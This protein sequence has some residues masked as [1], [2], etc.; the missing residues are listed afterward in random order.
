MD[1]TKANSRHPQRILMQLL[2]PALIL[3]FSGPLNLLAADDVERESALRLVERFSLHRIV[4]S[5][6]CF[7][8]HSATRTEGDLDLGRFDSLDS[9]QSDLK[10]WEAMIQQLETREMPPKDQPQ[11]TDQERT[12]LLRWIRDILRVEA[13]RHAGDPGHVPLHR[14]SNAEYDNTIRDLTGVDLKPTRDFPSDGAA[15]EGFTNAA[16]SLSM[17]PAMMTKYIGAAKE[18]ASHAILLPNGF[19]F[20]KS[21]T[22][23]D[24]TDDSL[25]AIRSFY[26]AFSEDGTLP[27]AAYMAAL[28]EHRDVIEARQKSTEDVAREK[29]LSPKYLALLW[30]ALHQDDAAYPL[31]R[32]QSIWRSENYSAVD[33]Y[34]SEV[35][36]WSERLWEFPRI[37]SYGSSHRQ[38]ARDPKLAESDAIAIMAEPE[39]GQNEV[40]LH[41]RA[42]QLTGRPQSV[43]WNNPRFVANGRADLMLH[44]YHSWGSRFEIDYQALFAQTTRYLEATIDAANNPGVS[45]SELAVRYGLDPPWLER[46]IQVL[47][48][49]PRTTT[50]SKSLS[51][52][53]A[54]MV[55]L[56]L[57]SEPA[58]S[59][60]RPS[61][62]GWKPVGADLPM[63][64]ANAS[65][66]TEHIPGRVAP[67]SIAVHPTPTEFVAVVWTSPVTG[68]VELSGR[69]E[70]VHPACGNGVVWWVELQAK[71]QTRIIDY[72]STG[73]GGSSD[74]RVGEWEVEVGDRM[75]LAIDSKEANHVCD[76]T[77][78]DFRVR[79][80]IASEGNRGWDLTNDVE[81]RIDRGNP[82]PGRDGREVVWSFVRGPSDQRASVLETMSEGETL[83]ERWR[84]SAADIDQVDLAKRLAI[85]LQTLLT[86][87]RPADDS[88]DQITY[89][90]LVSPYSELL[91]GVDLRALAPAANQS[92][93]GL[94]LDRFGMRPDDQMTAA[95]NLVTSSG[96][97]VEI[98]LPAALLSE[99][100]FAV[101]CKLG[102]DSDDQVLQYQVSLAPLSQTSAWDM[103]RPILAAANGSGR[104]NFL[105]GL[106][107]FRR[108]FPPH[109]CYPHI[110]PTDEVVC[111]KTFHR[112]DE[113]LVDLF[114]DDT[115]TAE[116]E[117][118]WSEHRFIS[119]F[120]LVENEYLPLFIGFVT[121]DQ[122]KELLEKFENMRPLFQQWADDFERDFE[123]A[124]PGQFEQLFAFAAKAYRRPLT[125]SDAAGLRRLYDSLRENEVT[126]EEAFRSVLGRVLLSPSFLM[127]LETSPSEETVAPVD[128]WELASRLSYFLWSSMPDDDLRVVAADGRLHEPSEIASQTRRMLNDP[129]ARSLAIE[130]GTQWIHV[131]E[132][133][134]F[135]EKNESLFPT[136]DLEL[137]DAM[138]EEAIQFFQHL[139]QHDEPVVD[140]VNADYTF[141]NQRLA[142][143]YGIP[144]VTG[145]DFRR[146]DDV[147]RLGRGGVL[148]FGSVHA[149]Q[150]G[151]SR[152]SPVLR[153]N[154][155]VETLLGEKLPLPPPNVPQLPESELGNDG[156][157]MREI[158]QRHVAD[159]QCASC[160]RRIDPFGMVFERYDSIGRYR[161][162]DLNGLPIDATSKLRDGTAIDGLDGLRH[163]L[164]SQRSEAI[165]RLFYR[166]LLGYALGRSVTISDHVLIDEMMTKTANGTTGVQDAVIAIVQS[167]QFGRIRGR[168]ESNGTSI[169]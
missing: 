58:S 50:E 19:R 6:Y 161:E 143:H 102:D 155:V 100:Y 62:Q 75:L 55:T 153:G 13:L 111:L 31:D 88:L 49:A 136:F 70:H 3:S 84:A 154:W 148:G 27:L 68:I 120:P 152:T 108:L 162:S 116:L 149:K 132:F 29:G 163:Y 24:W 133:D 12:E 91:G 109:V 16:E 57:L 59:L 61:I 9:V 46:W 5:K 123:E 28:V 86:G 159:P 14:L 89:D 17:S 76:L 96:E 104:T 112:E 118:L 7:E 78:V 151:S 93:W 15:G 99:Y 53:A 10:P 64:V 18:I 40:T 128:D 82:L 8:C 164:H 106:K 81:G 79:E 87:P 21:A 11:P 167:P 103:S 39:A 26:R 77:S 142:R 125:P 83:L 45:T 56:N 114:L 47:D 48:I 110:I 139:F 4:L 33:Q 20:S 124:A 105:Q 74:L 25:A 94:P 38:V 63:V 130:F 44:D 1:E 160:H 36:S 80:K 169:P 113:P 101:D 150:A 122:P 134:R 35:T 119:K 115:Q 137:R 135:S 158:V 66:A 65:D 138:Y 54:P 95:Q 165:V 85:E 166:R 140:V 92:M 41:L 32:L 2:C 73:I 34:L 146:V 147:R 30:L 90:H 121:Q 156:L 144:D 157:T 43:V 117:R 141:L 129:R 127:H 37:G 126:H 69:V 67:H 60:E 51:G 23:R 97:I 72:G 107:E 131:R 42:R 22:Q 145:E 98:R 71:S 52:I 168:H